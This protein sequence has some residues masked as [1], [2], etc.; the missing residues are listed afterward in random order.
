MP[1][2]C[3]ECKQKPSNRTAFYWVVAGFLMLGL[4]FW[5]ALT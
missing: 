1:C 2:G 5:N 4:A 3:Y